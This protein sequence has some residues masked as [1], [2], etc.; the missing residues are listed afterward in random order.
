MTEETAIKHQI[1]DY[2]KLKGIFYWYNLQG[3]GAYKG[4]PDM[5][6]V[7]DG[8]IYG[9]EVKRPKGKQS[10]NQLEFEGKFNT[11]GGKYIVARSLED[12]MSVL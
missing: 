5:C 8:V 6:A 11:A 9:I 3:M 2:L 10:E 12:I 4:I 7:K 1:K